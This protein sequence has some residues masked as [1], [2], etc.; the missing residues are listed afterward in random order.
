MKLFGFKSSNNLNFFK[1][2]INVSGV[3][4]K[5]ALG[6]ISNITPKEMCVAIATENIIVL[7]SIPG[8]GP[9][10]AQKIIFELKDKVQKE[11]LT[12]ITEKENIKVKNAKNINE[13]ITALEVLG[14]SKREITGV[15][16]RINISDEK[17][18]DIIR[19]ILKEM[20]K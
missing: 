19:L 3:G 2:L 10:M 13:A 15:I 5:M 6:I 7:K 1:K 11:D 12:N 14:Y 16:E 4:P 17:V 9:K 8:I 20:Q 18:E